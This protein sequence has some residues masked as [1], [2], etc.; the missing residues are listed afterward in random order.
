MQLNIAH[1]YIREGRATAISRIRDYLNNNSKINLG[2]TIPWELAV[3]LDCYGLYIPDEFFYYLRFAYSILDEDLESIFKKFDQQKIS[4]L[5]PLVRGRKGHYREL[6]ED[7][8][9]KGFL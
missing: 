7:I 9:K 2:D 6:F 5:A 8:R 3:T 4:L 1:L